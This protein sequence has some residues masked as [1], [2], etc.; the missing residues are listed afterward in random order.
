[1]MYPTGFRWPSNIASQYRKAGDEAEQVHRRESGSALSTDRMDPAE[2]RFPW[3]STRMSRSPQYFKAGG[4]AEQVHRRVVMV[5]AWTSA[6]MPMENSRG[7][8]HIVKWLVSTAL[9]IIVLVALIAVCVFVVVYT[10]RR[11]IN[12]CVG[13]GDFRAK[14]SPP[15]RVGEQ[16]RIEFRMP[17]IVQNANWWGLTMEDLEVD[18]YLANSHGIGNSATR[19]PIAHGS[20]RGVPIAPN[21]TTTVL[22]STSTSG[23]EVGGALAFFMAQCMSDAPFTHAFWQMDVHVSMAEF[24]LFGIVPVF[25]APAVSQFWARIAYPCPMSDALPWSPCPMPRCGWGAAEE[26]GWGCIRIGCDVLDGHCEQNEA[27]MADTMTI[28]PDD[29]CSPFTYRDR[30]KFPFDVSLKDLQP[31]WARKSLPSMG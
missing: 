15:T 4:E 11:P 22:F 21:G 20:Q 24:T 18:V 8:C 30:P 3:P 17:A 26:S 6:D 1:M 25:W 31:A 7:C 9:L 10:W 16:P 19:H 29:E 2:Y 13:Y 14:F 12:V 23:D 28:R 5:D 27:C